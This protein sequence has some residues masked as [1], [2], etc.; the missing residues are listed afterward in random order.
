VG[1][2]CSGWSSARSSAGD[3]T[4]RAPAG[5]GLA[6]LS[7]ATLGAV[8]FGL[9]V[10]F[11][12]A[13]ARDGLHAST[14]LGLR[15]SV[16]GALLVAALVALRRPLLPPRGERVRALGLGL[17][18][19]AL[20]ATCFY[21]ALERGTAAAV[22]LLFYGYPAVVAVAEVVAGATRLRP[23]T[24]LA[25]ALSVGG[26]AAVAAGGG[27]VAISATGVLF[28]VGSIACFS[29]YVLAS[30]R[31][32][33]R[34]DSLTAATWTALGAAVGIVLSGLAL[35]TLERPSG[36]AT[37]AI[38]ANGASTAAAFTIFFVVLTRIGPTRT[39]IVMTLEA[40]ASVALTALFLDEPVRGVV[41][42]GGVAVLAGAVLAA[43][44]T[45]PRVERLESAS[46]A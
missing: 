4:P 38:V 14:A 32:L 20:E 41:A 46:P 34:T 25:L 35:G 28:V 24:V 29:T 5:T 15:F 19:Y 18:L 6:H 2:S 26:G 1:C 8:L 31:L 42:L 16:A 45:S 9:T 23:P 11:N 13:V 40:V 37:A 3:A 22:A 7:L 43:R 17:V 36:G 12:R 44:A 21:S 27:R 30:A 10:L 33:R 39:A